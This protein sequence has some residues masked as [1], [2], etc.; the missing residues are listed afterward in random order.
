LLSLFFLLPFLAACSGGS[1]GSLPG[2]PA[3]GGANE[4]ST[5]AAQSV[6]ESPDLESALRRSPAWATV[7]WNRLYIGNVGNNSITV[8]D[9]SAAGNTPPLFSISGS[10]TQINDPG[11]LTEDG[12]GNLY[13]TNRGRGSVLVFA[14]GA[15]GNVAPIRVLAGTQTQITNIEAM[16]VD[17]VTGKLFVFNEPVTQAN[18]RGQAS[19]PSVV[20]ARV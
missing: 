15:R 8:Y 10:R 20:R 12:Q 13:V 11:Q 6:A 14:H 4:L 16:T 1:G 9:H 18:F 5:A 2:T 19:L 7:Y 3:G 17:Q